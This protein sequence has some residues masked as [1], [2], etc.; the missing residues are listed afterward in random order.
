[1][2]GV[3]TLPDIL[4]VYGVESTDELDYTDHPDV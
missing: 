4:D 3:V 2:L 1:M